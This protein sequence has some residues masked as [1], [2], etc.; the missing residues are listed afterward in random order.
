MRTLPALCAAVLL[1]VAHPASAGD[2][3]LGKEKSVT[4][5]ACHGPDGNSLVPTFPSLAGQHEDYLLHSMLSYQNGIRTNA[6]MVASLMQLSEEDL[7]D[8]AAYYA[9]QKGLHSLAVE[10]LGSR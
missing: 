5:T 4:C 10:P 7:A 6:I 9:R 3:A 1:L 8:L 2:P